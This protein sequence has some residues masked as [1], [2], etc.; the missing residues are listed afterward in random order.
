MSDLLTPSDIEAKAKE[1]GL[2]MKQ[3]CARADI[4]QS[5]FWRWK[6]GM[7]EPTLDVYRRLR[8]AIAPTESTPQEAAE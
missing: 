8:D 2:S 3:V 7:T 6:N 5:T 4:A 1:A